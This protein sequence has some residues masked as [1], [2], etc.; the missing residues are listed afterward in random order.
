MN[1]KCLFGFHRWQKVGGAT[2]IGHGKFRLQVV[3]SEC[4]KR[5]FII[6]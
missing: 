4:G 1:L 3:C 6:D 5:K 2:N